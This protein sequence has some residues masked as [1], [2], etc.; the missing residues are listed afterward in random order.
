MAHN[1][2]ESD[3]GSAATPF[4]REAALSNAVRWSEA[5]ARRAKAIAKP[6]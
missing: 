6:S 5:L 4:S 1:P 3:W 2:N